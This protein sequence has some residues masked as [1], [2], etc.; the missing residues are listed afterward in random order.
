MINNLDIASQ[1]G[2]LNRRSQAFVG[3]ACADMGIGFSECVLLIALYRR[4]GIN[5]EDMSAVLF[6]DKA[7]VARTIK[8]LEEK[9]FI[10]REQTDED[11]RVKKLYLTEKGKATKKPIFAILDKWINFLNDGMDE[12]T[13]HTVRNGL[14]KLA[15]KA[16]S[17]EYSKLFEK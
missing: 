6:I 10:K 17:T 5:Q 11:K 14:K 16:S 4:E 15:D 3:T 8:S 2:I 9:G 13:F 12:E 7:A 1:F